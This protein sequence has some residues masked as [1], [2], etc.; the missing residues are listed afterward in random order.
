MAGLRFE[1]LRSILPR[2]FFHQ[3]NHPRVA[4]MSVLRAIGLGLR[5][6][7]RRELLSQVVRRVSR[8]VARADSK[9]T[10]CAE[11]HKRA[12][13]RVARIAVQ[14]LLDHLPG[15]LLLLLPQ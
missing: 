2:P 5:G 1:D 7:R 13:R 6:F 3:S 8:S 11:I 14:Q 10:G 9:R 4:W 12:G 15:L